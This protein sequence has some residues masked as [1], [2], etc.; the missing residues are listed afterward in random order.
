MHY[1]DLIKLQLEHKII[2]NVVAWTATSVA[3]ITQFSNQIR[4]RLISQLIKSIWRVL[5]KLLRYFNGTILSTFFVSL[6]PVW[7]VIFSSLISALPVHLY[8]VVIKFQM[9]F[10]SFHYILLNY[11][12]ELLHQYFEHHLFAY[13]LL[14]FYS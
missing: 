12:L 3:T 11:T 14:C 4:S 6:L 5:Q 10:N 8:N 1:L 7:P 9:F 13:C 2:E